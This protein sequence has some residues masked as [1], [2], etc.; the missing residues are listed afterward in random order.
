MELTENKGMNEHVI[1]QIKGKQAP[2]G[3]IY[4]LG[5]VE[6]ETLKTYIE[7]HLKTRFIRPS[8]SPPGAAI[9]LDKSP[10]E[11][12]AYVLII[13]AWTTS[14]SRIGTLSV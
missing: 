7:I 8:K 14:R 13:G 2:Y 5:P 10:M 11:A 1:E 4:S 9:L 3:P 12:F 6:L